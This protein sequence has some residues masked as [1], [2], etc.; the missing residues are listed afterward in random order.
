[1][2]FPRAGL[3]LFAWLAVCQV[4]RAE[5]P[6]VTETKWVNNWEE[7][8]KGRELLR[9]INGRWWSEDNREVTPP[10]MGSGFWLLDSKPGTGEFF[11]H[12]PFALGRA[13]SLQLFMT[14][15]EVEAVLGPP[16]R[17]LGKGQNG[18]WFYYASNGT[19]VDIWFVDDGVLGDAKYDT[20]GQKSWRVA[21]VERDLGGRDLF[22]VLAER[23]RDRSNQRSAQRTQDFR[24]DQGARMEALRQRAGSTS[25]GAQPSVVTV[26]PA[27]AA[28][29]AA[30]KRMVAAE[31]IAAITPGTGRDDVLA[32]LGEP[33]ARFSIAG[34]EGA[35]ESFTYDLDNGETVII[36]LL[37][38]KVVKV[39]R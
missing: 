7:R 18:H 10:A 6:Y 22:K 12:R 30:P 24:S 16:N 20:P 23:A 27:S 17:T 36:R 8:G 2:S 31:A 38:G 29:P 33:S 5:A 28:Q 13:E 34:D 1:M 4:V 3:C 14:H 26:A 9:K 21:S 11:H 15:E 39:Q 35:R 19:K 32:R 25:R 37:D